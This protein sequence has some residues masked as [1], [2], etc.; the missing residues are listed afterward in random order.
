MGFGDL[1]AVQT[2]EDVKGLAKLL[3][4]ETGDL[5][6]TSAQQNAL[7]NEANRAVFREL[8]DTNP[9]YFLE[10]TTG[11]FTWTAD[12]ESFDIKSNFITSIPYKIIGIEETEKSAAIS[13]TNIPTKWRPMRFQDR[14]MVHGM[15]GWWRGE[16]SRYYCLA[17]KKLF[18][19]PI[20]GEAINFHIYWIKNIEKLSSD[21]HTVLRSTQSEENGAA[22]AY[23]DLVAVYLAKLMNSK[24]QGQNP[25]IDQLWLEGLDRMKDNAHSRNVDEPSHVRV[26]RAP[27]D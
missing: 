25:M 3:L 5:F 9:E 21:G 6:W 12:T 14:T 16:L 20:P 22:D 18:V 4:D 27:W 15:S 7:A 17:G 24:Q 1:G 8:V 10:S 23:G 13:P 2:L 19:A 11:P 26:T